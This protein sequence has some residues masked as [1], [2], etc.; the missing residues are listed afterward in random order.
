MNGPLIFQ[1]I[2][3]VL[4]ANAITLLGVYAVAKSNQTE[5]KFGEAS[6]RYII[7]GLICAALTVVVLFA[8]R[9]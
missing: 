5:A 7:M 4:V 9:G 3:G 6:I 8:A 2:L 1:I